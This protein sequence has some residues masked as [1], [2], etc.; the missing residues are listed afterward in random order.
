MDGWMDGQGGYMEWFDGWVD[1]MLELMDE[2]MK[3]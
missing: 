3:E 2:W 1:G